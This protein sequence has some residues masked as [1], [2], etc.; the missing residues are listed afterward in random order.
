MV[1]DF[2]DK[3]IACN[4]PTDN[5]KLKELVLLVQ[6]HKHSTYCK[7]NKQC[8]FSFP[9]PPSSC[10]LISQPYSEDDTGCTSK[11]V[12]ECLSKVRKLLIEGNTNVSHLQLLEMGNT[13]RL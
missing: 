13:I 5:E 4:I 9:Q 10:T 6:Q 12:A 1:C 7:R 8:R 11:S 2:I 3:Y